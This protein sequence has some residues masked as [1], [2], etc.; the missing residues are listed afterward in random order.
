MGAVESA[1]QLSK[2]QEQWN[3]MPRVKL[4]PHHVESCRLVV[5]R[6]ALLDGVPKGGRAAE[7]GVAFGDFSSEILNRIRPD[8]LHLIDMWEAERYSAG[9]AKVEE[10]FAKEI[11]NGSVKLHVGSSLE[12]LGTFDDGFFDFIYIDTTHSY[13]LTLSELRLGARKLK[14]SGLLAGHDFCVGN[15]VKPVVYGVIQACHQ[16]CSEDGWRYRAIS[17]DAG[18]SFSF[19]LER[20]YKRAD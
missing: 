20:G 5:S 4:A 14:P 18:G 6:E 1:A 11:A 13:H 17:L 19:C 3:S 10:K 15:V 7:L 16:F 9:R 8:E 2:R 12:M